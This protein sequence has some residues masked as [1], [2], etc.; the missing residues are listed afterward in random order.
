MAVRAENASD[1][2]RR[3][4]RSQI[5]LAESPAAP[6]AR[7]FGQCR[8]LGHSWSHLSERLDPEQSSSRWGSIG[9]RSQCDYCGTVRTKWMT[10]S[11]SLGGS[12]YEYPD[13]YS[14][15][16]EDRL[17]LEQWRQTWLVTLMGDE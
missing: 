14:Q 1:R 4:R 9:F 3:R 8:S 16:G 7:R 11:G 2:Q 12:T 5:T 6:L 13:G 15:H 17:P 10:R